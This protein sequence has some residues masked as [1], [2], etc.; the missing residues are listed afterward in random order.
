MVWGGRSDGRGQT[1]CMTDETVMAREIVISA[2]FQAVMSLRIQVM[3]MGMKSQS[4]M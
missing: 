2:C 1:L 3:V 4:D